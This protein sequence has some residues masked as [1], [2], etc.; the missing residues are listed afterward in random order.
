MS[1]TIEREFEELDAQCRWQPLYLVSLR[2]ARRPGA[3]EDPSSRLPAP[4]HLPRLPLGRKWRARAASGVR[5]RGRSSPLRGLELKHRGA[6]RLLVL[7]AA[8]QRRLLA[9]RPASA[10]GAPGGGSRGT[11][12]GVGRCP[13]SSLTAFLS[14]DVRWPSALVAGA[15]KRARDVGSGPVKAKRGPMESRSFAGVPGACGRGSIPEPELKWRRE[16]L[17]DR[18]SPVF[19]LAA[20][21]G[22]AGHL[23]LELPGTRNNRGFGWLIID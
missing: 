23:L 12:R 19:S 21:F 10:C 18:A 9:A 16:L 1:A 3:S 14:A 6:G 5:L 11:R 13:A 7:K 4:C 20:F 22:R 2:P 15:A 17:R 8:P